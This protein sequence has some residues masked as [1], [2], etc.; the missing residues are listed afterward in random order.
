MLQGGEE[1]GWRAGSGLQNAFLSLP[2]G[3]FLPFQ[4]RGRLLRLEETWGYKQPG[5]PAAPKIETFP[6]VPGPGCWPFR[7]CHRH[8]GAGGWAPAYPPP[9]PLKPPPPLSSPAGSRGGRNAGG[10]PSQVGS[11]WSGGR[12]GPAGPISEP[13]IPRVRPCEGSEALVVYWRVSPD[14]SPVGW[15]G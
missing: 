14:V 7:S 5:E 10:R 15:G 11:T 12:T 2:G 4:P 6:D 3:P 13:L 1:D 9:D 8:L